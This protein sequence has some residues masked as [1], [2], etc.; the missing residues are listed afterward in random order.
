ML[1]GRFS[2]PFADIANPPNTLHQ[3]QVAKFLNVAQLLAFRTLFHF[4]GAEPVNGFQYA[5]EDPVGFRFFLDLSPKTLIKRRYR[6]LPTVKPVYTQKLVAISLD[7]LLAVNILFAVILIIVM[8]CYCLVIDEVFLKTV[9]L[10]DYAVLLALVIT[11]CQKEVNFVRR[12]PVSVRPI[13]LI[14]ITSDIELGDQRDAA[15]I[16]VLL[17]QG[18]IENPAEDFTFHG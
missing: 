18:S 3:R 6:V 4:I 11:V 12:M 10:N 14:K 5:A 16:T 17:P 1:L 13:K 2:H 15:I 9:V 7:G 8:G